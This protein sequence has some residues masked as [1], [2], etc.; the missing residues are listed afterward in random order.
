MNESNEMRVPII[1]QVA[2]VVHDLDER[3]RQLA[4][5]IT[6]GDRG[7]LLPP[8][9]HPIFRSLRRKRSPGDIHLDWSKDIIDSLNFELLQPVGNKAFAEWLAAKTATAP[10]VVSHLERRHLRQRRPCMTSLRQQGGR[11]GSVRGWM[12]SA[13]LHG[14]AGRHRPRSGPGTSHRCALFEATREGSRGDVHAARRLRLGRRL[15]DLRARLHVAVDERT[16]VPL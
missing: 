7:A 5:V 8:T 4:I 13:I 6:A 14:N 10:P 9:S 3:V 11:V 12:E 2:Y 16:G 1:S 15:T